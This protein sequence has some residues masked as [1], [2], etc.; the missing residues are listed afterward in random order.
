[1]SSRALT[2]VG[3]AVAARAPP[4][5]PSPHHN[6]DPPPPHLPRRAFQDHFTLLYYVKNNGN[7]D[8]EIVDP[9]H[10]RRQLARIHYPHLKVENVRP[11]GK[12]VIFGKQY[13]VDDYGCPFTRETLGKENQRCARRASCVRAARAHARARA[14][15]PLCF[16]RA[17]HACARARYCVCAAQVHTLA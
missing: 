10:K 16:V 11:G 8:V 2:C 1:M 15:A 7:T 5:A 13:S 9:K 6:L 4:P 14:R 17:V 3:A 12:L